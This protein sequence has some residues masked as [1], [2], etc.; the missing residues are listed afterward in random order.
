METEERA[1][2]PERLLEVCAV[3]DFPSGTKR[4][5]DVGRFGIGVFN[6]N[7]EFYAVANHCP[8]EGGPLCAGRQGGRTVVDE[9]AV[10]ET[11]LVRDGEWIY[12]PW[13]QWGISLKTGTTAVKPEWS[14]RTYPVRVVDGRVFVVR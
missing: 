14:V 10:G 4:I 9:G 3:E 13:H 6:V 8:H 5:L 1:V 7:G 12:C 2:R 11:A